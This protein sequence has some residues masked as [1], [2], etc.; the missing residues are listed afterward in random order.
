M[1]D[2]KLPV[3]TRNKKHSSKQFVPVI[4]KLEKKFFAAGTLKGL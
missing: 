1:K 2:K 3:I 4:F